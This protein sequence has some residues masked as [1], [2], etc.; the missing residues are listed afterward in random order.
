MWNQYLWPLMVIQP[1]EYRPVMIGA[2]Y[3]Y[4]GGGLMAY[5]SI[6]T[7]PVLTI[8][9]VLQRNFMESMATTGVK[10]T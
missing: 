1:E 4:Q 5:L 2:Q 8:F 10:G 9:L 3:F 6:I 7:L